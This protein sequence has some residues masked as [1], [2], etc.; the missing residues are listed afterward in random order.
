MTCGLKCVCVCVGWGVLWKVSKV[1]IVFHAT[2]NLY[3]VTIFLLREDC[4]VCLCRVKSKIFVKLGMI[5]ALDSLWCLS[6]VLGNRDSSVSIVTRLR[7]GRP[8]FDFLQGQG[9]FSL[10][11]CCV[12]TGSGAHPAS[13]PMATG[14]SFPGLKRLGREADRSPQY[15]FVSWCLDKHRDNFTFTTLSEI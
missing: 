7:A 2:C 9:L 8:W 1:H 5:I 11:H 15:V 4:L 6:T 14:G 3:C 10:H 13:Y 12:Q